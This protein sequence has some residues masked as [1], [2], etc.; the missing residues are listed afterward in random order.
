MENMLEAINSRLE[1]VEEKRSGLEGIA[2]KTSPS[3]TCR[4]KRI[5]KN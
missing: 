3:E 5:Q 4:T 2:I 1:I